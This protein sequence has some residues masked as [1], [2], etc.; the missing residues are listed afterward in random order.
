MKTSEMV[1]LHT[2]LSQIAEM[3]EPILSQ[4]DDNG[5]VADAV[6]AKLDN[7]ALTYET[8]AKN[9][10]MPIGP[11]GLMLMDDSFKNV[12]NQEARNRLWDSLMSA[13]EEVCGFKRE[14]V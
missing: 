14:E 4:D 2:E 6:Y 12:S 3:L 11:R 5:S 7:M 1:A 13:Y 9:N 8:M 10:A